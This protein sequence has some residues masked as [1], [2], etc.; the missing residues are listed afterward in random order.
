[1]TAVSC[2]NDHTVKGVCARVCVY[3]MEVRSERAEWGCLVGGRRYNVPL[4]LAQLQLPRSPVRHIAFTF[5]TT[6][7]DVNSIRSGQSFRP[8]GIPSKPLFIAQIFRNLSLEILVDSI[9]NFFS[10][11]V[12]NVL[13]VMF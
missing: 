10:V 4:Q 1:M 11:Q 5:P 12:Q 13:K 3:V 6:R 2:L 7:M 9:L 8:L